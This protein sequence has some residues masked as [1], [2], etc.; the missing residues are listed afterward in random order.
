PVS[1][2]HVEHGKVSQTTTIGSEA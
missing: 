1:M 2:F